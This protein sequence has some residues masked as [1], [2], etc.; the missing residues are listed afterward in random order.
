M[1]FFE[2]EIG[3][4]ELDELA[5]EILKLYGEYR[6]FSFY[7]G[8]GAGKTTLI[9]KLVK[10]LNGQKASSP[11]FSLV[12]IYPGEIPVNHFDCYRIE[13]EKDIK[14]IGFEDYF[15]SGDYCFIE[16]PEIIETLIP[17]NGIKV[18]MSTLPDE[19]KRL[20]SIKT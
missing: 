7:G 17:E 5:E 18:Y 10:K 16:W 8:M 12:N 6:I 9:S 3:L 19:N 13:T 15:F 4:N 2:K 11:T 14:S 1:D 20:V